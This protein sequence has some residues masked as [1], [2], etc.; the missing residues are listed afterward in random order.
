MLKLNSIEEQLFDALANGEPYDPDAMLGRAEKDRTAPRLAGH[1][2][3][4]PRWC[5]LCCSG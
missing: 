2:R 4:A 3:F 1:T 5:A